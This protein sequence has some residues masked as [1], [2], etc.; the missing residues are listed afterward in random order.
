MSSEN[1]RH[2]QRGKLPARAGRPSVGRL[3][4]VR[5]PFQLATTLAALPYLGLRK[6]RLAPEAMSTL[7]F[8]QAQHSE[9][10]AQLTMVQAPRTLAGQLLRSAA[11]DVCQA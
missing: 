9:L 8:V 2:S 6:S 5:S 10:E 4:F 7:P 11:L 3:D 1:Q